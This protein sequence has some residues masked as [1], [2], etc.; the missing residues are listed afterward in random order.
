M[1][2][3]KFLSELLG[4]F[5]N[6][7]LA[8]AAYNAGSRRGMSVWMAR[9]GGLPGETRNYVARITGRQAERW[10]SS[11]AVRDPEATLMPAKAPC[12]EVVEAVGAGQGG[13]RRRG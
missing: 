2:W 1:S 3:G 5:G 9:R 12:A 7:G 13:Q 4:Q 11:D 8:A 6:L 10:T